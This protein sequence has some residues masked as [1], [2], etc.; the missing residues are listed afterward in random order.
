MPIVELP[1][2]QPSNGIYTL[3]SLGS[4]WSEAREGN[5][6][7]LHLDYI[8]ATADVWEGEFAA[9]QAFLEFDITNMPTGD[10]VITEIKLSMYLANL[11][12]DYSEIMIGL[13]QYDG[14]S[15]PLQDQHYVPASLIGGAVAVAGVQLPPTQ[16]SGFVDLVFD[17]NQLIPPTTPTIKFALINVQL[18]F[19]SPPT[20]MSEAQFL[21]PH[22]DIDWRPKLVVEYFDASSPPSV[23][24]NLTAVN[25]AGGILLDWEGEGHTYS[26]RS[27]IWT[28]EGDPP[29]V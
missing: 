16:E 7:L 4:S 27:E 20:G 15:Y 24:T 26:V 5:P 28:S 19:T 18:A 10:V 21:S 22:E 29:E 8:S 25:T 23:P 1:A 9:S 11:Y 2:I 3:M 12:L 6:P 13:V 14:W 17:L